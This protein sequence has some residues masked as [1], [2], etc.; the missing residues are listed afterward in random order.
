MNSTS[1]PRPLR[2]STGDKKIAG[3]AGGLAEHLG[4]D[5]TLVRA[6]FAISIL[7]S[8]AGLVAYLLLLAI[9]PDDAM[10]AAAAPPTA[11]AA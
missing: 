4:L 6:G 1:S 2:R 5:P 11:A 8:G 9:V 7:F 10:P 3:V